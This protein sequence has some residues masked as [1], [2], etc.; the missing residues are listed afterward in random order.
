[1]SDHDTTPKSSGGKRV[2]ILGGGV[3]GL[4]VA[5][6]LRPQLTDQD[7]V[8]V[9]DRTGSHVQGLSL[10]WVLRGWRSA[11]DV[12]ATPSAGSLPGVELV[13]G[14]VLEIDL[15][16]HQV[17]TSTG[18]RPYDALVIALG[19]ELDLDAIPGLRHALDQGTVGEFNTPAG[20][21]AAHDRL[22]A[23]R[24]GRLVVVVASTPYRC[25]ASPW[26]AALLADDLLREAGVRDD[27]E[28]DV[29]TPEPQPMPI[30]GPTLGAAIVD[31]LGTRGIGAHFN[32]A[33]TA[34]HDTHVS[35]ND[36]GL[37][38]FTFALVVPPHRP[39]AAIRNVESFSGGWIP[40]D[41]RTLAVSETTPGVWALGDSAMA[42]LPDG[43]PL[44]KAA[45][46][47]RG[48]AITVA[49]GVAAYLGRP[50][51]HVD[52][53]GVGHCYLEVGAH[54]AAKGAGNFYAPGGPDVRLEAANPEL[55]RAKQEE[56]SA[57]LEQ[58]NQ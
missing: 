10:L 29:Y 2:L 39:P 26:E 53:D 11:G 25:P 3:G 24:S 33:L 34:L 46:F 14:I 32:R 44:P 47:A 4:S 36:Q 9:V 12:V 55:H 20:A 58:W 57:W 6:A 13:N 22:Q 35:F 31:L 48:Q 37:T 17:R 15:D 40:V 8:T 50:S 16:R 30:A 51:T 27:V 49:A 56:E 28:I 18:T 38:D 21:T 42:P 7:T 1:M 23:L 54:E 45:V 43:R 52:F 5:A 19:A 41:P